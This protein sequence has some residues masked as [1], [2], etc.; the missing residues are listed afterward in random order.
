MRADYP[1]QNM[2]IYRVKKVEEQY[3]NLD[4]HFRNGTYRSVIDALQY[5]TKD[6]R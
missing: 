6:E 5:S 2:Q 4:D 3:G 1:T